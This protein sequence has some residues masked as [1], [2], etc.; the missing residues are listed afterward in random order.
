[1]ELSRATPLR[2]RS[3]SFPSFIS[4]SLMLDISVPP[5]LL[6]WELYFELYSNF[7]HWIFHL[8]NTCSIV[9]SPD[10]F[11][12]TL[13]MPVYSHGPHWW[14]S[15]SEASAV[16]WTVTFSRPRPHLSFPP[17]YPL[18]VAW[19]LVS[20]RELTS[21]YWACLP[22]EGQASFRSFRCI[23]M[24]SFICLFSFKSSLWIWSK[25]RHYFHS[26]RSLIPVFVETWRYF[27]SQS[28][29]ND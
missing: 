19:H 7:E 5:K 2:Q 21:V 23:R 17:L 11:S 28:I 25:A 26:E 16:T 22:W 27:E 14:L 24:L 20:K 3:S 18:Q 13:P 29:E 4:P 12:R 1:M 6:H 8:A 15:I 9:S 10:T